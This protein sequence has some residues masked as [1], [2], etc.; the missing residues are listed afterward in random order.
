MRK[1]SAH[2][3]NISFSSSFNPVSRQESE[4][5]SCSSASLTDSETKSLASAKWVFSF[6]FFFRIYFVFGF[7]LV[8][9]LH[10]DFSDLICAQMNEESVCCAG[11]FY[12][13]SILSNDRDG[14]T[15]FHRKHPSESVRNNYINP[16]DQTTETLVEPI[17]RS[18]LKSSKPLDQKT[19]NE[20]VSE[21]LERILEERERH[22]RLDRSLSEI[23]SQEEHLSRNR[24]NVAMS[25]T[26]QKALTEAILRKISQQT[27]DNDQDILDQHVSRVFSPLVSPGT[28]SP[29]Q[30]IAARPL[31]PLPTLVESVH[32]NTSFGMR[33]SKSIPCK[34][35]SNNYDSGISLGYS[36][37]KSKPT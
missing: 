37:Y 20:L 15:Y 12:I 3:Y 29:H 33:H 23:Q 24:P 36:T 18:R 30:T 1:C 16:L 10:F 14:Q 32:S 8:F 6:H 31:P 19:F 4:Y 17:S 22:D 27:E 13:F 25:A 7:P 11:W 5:H 34:P 21:K 26:H 2:G 35:S 9:I 28:S